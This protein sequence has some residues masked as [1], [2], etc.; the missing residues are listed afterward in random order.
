[1]I[2]KPFTAF[3]L[4][5]VSIVIML[6]C[7][8]RK[9]GSKQDISIGD[10]RNVH[11]PDTATE[12]IENSQYNFVYQTPESEFDLVYL[13]TIEPAVGNADDFARALRDF[14]SASY[15]GRAFVWYDLNVSDTMIGK[16]NGLFVSGY[17]IETNLLY[18]QLFCF[19]T[20]ANTKCYGFCTFQQKPGPMNLASKQFFRSIQFNIDDF[21]ESH[22]RTAS[23]KLHKPI[24]KIWH[25]T[26]DFELIVPPSYDSSD[27]N[28]S[29]PPK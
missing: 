29:A 19:L 12:T 8:R 17:T 25:F 16:V 18:K 23:L 5:I 26:P 6:S 28:T 9:S 21:N 20:I 11:F 7:A 2:R 27:N 4:L 10:L 14:A 15:S 3:I 24:G 13:D 1:M 22:F